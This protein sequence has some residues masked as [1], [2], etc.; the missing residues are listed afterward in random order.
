MRRTFA[1]AGLKEEGAFFMAARSVVSTTG[2][3]VYR[4]FVLLARCI[5]II[6]SQACSVFSSN[7]GR[8]RSAELAAGWYTTRISVLRYR[9]AR[10]ALPL[11]RLAAAQNAAALARSASYQDVRR[12]VC[13]CIC[14]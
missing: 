13:L 2:L 6:S 3:D 10:H 11:R 1:V 7:G 9:A 12:A 8:R 5:R 4:I 14:A